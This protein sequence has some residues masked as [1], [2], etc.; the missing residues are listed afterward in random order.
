MSRQI[1]L[2]EGRADQTFYEA[3]CR[4]ANR[5]NV[6]V[7]TPKSIG[8]K[9]DTKTH[10]IHN[11]PFVLSQ[12]ED[13]S[14]ANLGL[15]VDADYDEEHGLGFKGTLEKIREQALSFGF[16]RETRL[17]S[18]GFVFRHPDGLPQFGLWIMPDNRSEGMLEDFV[19]LSITE[20]IQTS[21]HGHACNVTSKLVSPL[22]KKIHKSK[23]EVATWLAWQQKPGAH[24]EVTIGD[25]LIDLASP[26]LLSLVSWIHAVF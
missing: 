18:G 16:E 11:L 8:G 12:L 24:I 2:V 21:L 17:Q 19:K 23:A 26:A 25:G 5:D 9:M 6:K 22:F 20:S 1:L 10:A 7:A 14:I 15:V 3:L 4:K 13:G